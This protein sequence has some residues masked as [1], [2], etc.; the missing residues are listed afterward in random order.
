MSVWAQE[1]EGK[2]ATISSKLDQDN[3]FRLMGL[4][5]GT[6]TLSADIDGRPLEATLEI[7]PDTTTEVQLDLELSAGSPPM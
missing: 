2:W 4:W 1:K 3:R 5:P 6:W 7:S